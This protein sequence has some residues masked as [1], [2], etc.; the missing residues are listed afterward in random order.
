MTERTI[1]LAEDKLEKR[2]KKL[3]TKQLMDILD[4]EDK[5]EDLSTS[6]T[7]RCDYI[8]NSR[9]MIT[10]EDKIDYIKYETW[11]RSLS[12]KKRLNVDEIF[13]SYTGECTHILVIW[14]D[15]FHCK[16]KAIMNYIHY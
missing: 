7:K 14:S 16:N 10:Y 9:L 1:R 15:R 6:N 5:L 12:S 11:I 4:I 3:S 13:F 8:S 2:I